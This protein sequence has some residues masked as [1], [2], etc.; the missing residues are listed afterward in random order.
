MYKLSLRCG[1][2]FGWNPFSIVV[3]P[4][5]VLLLFFYGLSYL[6]YTEKY[7]AV[8]VARILPPHCWVWTLITFSFYNP[9]VFGVISDILTIYLV[10][11]FIL[12]SWRWLEVTKFF[13]VIQLI[14]ALLC[15]FILFVGYAITSDMDLLWNVPIHGL[16]PLLG[17]VLIAAR[18][19][20]PDTVLAKLPLGKFRMK[21]VP[22]A[23]LLAVFLGA[24]FRI[25]Y[26]I[27]VIAVTS[28]VIISWIY[29]R[30]YQK[31]PNG[32]I[33]DT[34]DA[35]K[36]SGCFPNHLEPPISI[37]SN[38]IYNFLVRIRLCRKRSQVMT[39]APENLSVK[40]VESDPSSRR[41]QLALQ[42]LREK[43]PMP[44]AYTSSLLDSPPQTQKEDPSQSSP[45]IPRILEP[46][47]ERSYSVPVESS[48]NKP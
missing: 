38:T 19:V 36:F 8:T 17:G 33:G 25:L 45:Q 4:V 40:I 1:H 2:L 41:R 6:E 20:T 31:H 9:N 32:D 24:A 21:H 12:S 22:F 42:V 43:L 35:F 30:F 29:L 5:T 11:I 27:P 39:F 26:F 44:P 3:V 48:T 13:L 34:T 14:S 18:Q 7:L 10:Y 23:C 28:G 37:A 16:C 46:I 47:P 15:V